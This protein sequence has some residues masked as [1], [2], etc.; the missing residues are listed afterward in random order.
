MSTME[1][2]LLVVVDVEDSSPRRPLV[3]GHFRQ[4]SVVGTVSTLQ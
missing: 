4:V 2:I 3:P 1:A